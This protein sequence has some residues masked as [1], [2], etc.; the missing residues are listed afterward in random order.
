MQNFSFAKAKP[1]IRQCKL[2]SE[3]MSVSNSTMTSEMISFIVPAYNEERLIGGTLAALHEAMA[4]LRRDYEI[5]VVDDNSSDQ[6]AAIA[7]NAGARVIPV[8]LRH[9]AA[10]RNAG[11]CQAAGNLLFFVD[12]DT[13]V[14]QAVITAALEVLRQGAVGGGAAVR[15]GGELPRYA[16][17][18]VALGNWFSRAV[19]LAAGCFLFC[20]RKAFQATG[21]FDETFYCAEELVFSQA[22]KRHGRLVILREPV[23]TS[24]RKLRSYSVWKISRIVA[25]M[26]VR[27]PKSLKQRRGL[28][29]W[30]KPERH[31]R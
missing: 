3:K 2:K 13:Q 4:G 23:V 6:T 27:G 26:L 12:A 18:F 25:S 24:G 30:Y 19:R 7:A 29:F 16:K 28:E 21:G 17:F 11:A 8:Y 14:N 9:I 10:T 20:T 5:I 22:L 15:F 1:G 31:D